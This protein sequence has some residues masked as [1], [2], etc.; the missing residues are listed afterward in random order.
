MGKDNGNT[1]NSW[2][3]MP[4][5]LELVLQGGKSAITG[6]Q[7]GKTAEELGYTDSLIE[8]YMAEGAVEGK[9]SLGA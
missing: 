8:E 1:T 5:I 3:N 6:K 4:K 9:K 7:I 2:L